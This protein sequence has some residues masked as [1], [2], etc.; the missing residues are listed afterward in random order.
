MMMQK[1]MRFC[2]RRKDELKNGRWGVRTM[3]FSQ[4]KTIG[5]FISKMFRV[6]DE[7]FFAALDR[8]SRRLDYDVAVF[9]SAGYYLA[10]SD[11]DVQEKNILR[12]APLDK[13][14]GIIAVPSTYEKGEF[15][16]LVYEMLEKRVRC[17]LVVVREELDTHSCV[18]TDNATAMRLLTRHLIEQHHLTNICIQIGD[19]ENPEISVRLEGFKQEMA[20]HGLPVS[21]KN[22]CQGN[23]WTNSGDVAY[24]AFFSDPDHIPQAVVCANDY[25]AIGLIRVL[26]EKGYRVPEDVIVTGFDNITDWCTDVPSLTTIQPDYPG[27]V[28][29]AMELLDRQIRG[30]GR[31]REKIRLP[32]V[33]VCGESCGC[34][35]RHAD[36]YRDMTK[37][38]MAQQEAENDQDAAMNNM[39]IDLGA[40]TDLTELHKAMIGKRTENPIVRDHYICLFGTAEKLMQE[41]SAGACLVHAV[42]DHMDAGMPMISFDRDCLLPPMAERKDEAQVLYIK[43]LHQAG[44]NFGYSVIHYDQGKTPSRR[45]VQT[46]VLLSIALENIR[47]QHEMQE[48]YEERRLSSITDHMT[49][50]LNRRGLLESVEPLWRSMTGR[51]IAF[52]CI[53]MDYLKHTND[54]FGHAAGDVAIS[55]IGKAIQKSMPEEAM[56]ARTGGDEFIIFLPDAGNDRATQFVHRFNKT[57]EELSQA[58]RRSFTV[59]ASVGFKIVKPDKDTTVEECIRASDRILYQIKENRPNKIVRAGYNKWQMQQMP[60]PFGTA[61]ATAPYYAKPCNERLAVLPEALMKM[62]EN[63]YIWEHGYVAGKPDYALTL[64]DYPNIYSFIHTHDLDADAV[65]QVLSDASL[66]VHRKAF[67]QEEIDLLLGDDQAKAMAHFASPSTIVIGEKGYSEK[68]MYDHAATSWQGEGITPGMVI[69]ALPH[70]YNPLF[71]QKAADAFS[72]KLY[73]YTGMVTPVKWNQ[74]KAGDIK[75]DGS[76]EKGYAAGKSVKLDVMEFCQYTDYPTGCESV[77]LYML[78][79][80]YGVNVTVDQIIDLMPMGAQPYDDENGVRHGANPE[81]EFV[82]DPRK[83]ISYGVFNRPVAQVAEQIMPGVKTKTGATID[84]IKAILDT[85]NPV[86]AWYVSAPMRPIMYRWSWLDD[87]GETVHWPGGEHAVVVCAYDNNSLTYRDPNS[88]T[89]VEI[90]YATFEKGFSE[91]GGRIIYYERAQTS[92]GGA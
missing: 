35:K 80:Y 27:M 77:S 16:D 5:V 63:G 62:A 86:M 37:K 78:L 23:L 34:G 53:D 89:T 15:R 32:G 18:F 50:L 56:G 79:N 8:E 85:G 41:N 9:L 73:K 83:Q 40:C 22:I 55:M 7:A 82:G 4:R 39:S 47:R 72:R 88:G 30:E 17:P 68:W 75:P 20:A 24:R 59:S 81:R 44:H 90:D 71:V 65:R 43:L 92:P 6:F 38:L 12:F 87:R 76:E 21:E 28:S 69:A 31:E 10:K 3:I 52:I 45:F 74:W 26:Q 11:Y 66:M 25:M 19:F 29:Q 60:V 54:T 51:E 49:G 57:L 46:N 64:M 48:L 70:Y 42:R 13:L 1:G 61:S 2:E 67:T 58:E 84:E 91:M 14:D 33:L 36:F